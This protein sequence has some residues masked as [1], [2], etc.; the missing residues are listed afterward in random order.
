MSEHSAGVVPPRLL[1]AL[2]EQ[3]ADCP[4]LELLLEP[5]HAEAADRERIERHVEFCPI[6]AGIVDPASDEIDDLTWRGVERTL[7][8]RGRPWELRA[9]VS[10]ARERPRI[11][12]AIAAAALV[13][14]GGLAV[15][16]LLSGSPPPPASSGVLRG[17]PIQPLEPA[18]AVDSV[19]VFRWRIAAP[20]EAELHVEVERGE[21]PLWTPLWSGVAGGGSL[22]AP[23]SLREQL[24][25]GEY[26]WRVSGVDSQGAV[27]ARSVWVDFQIE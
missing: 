14:L 22:E 16:R 17:A 21:A 1:A 15:W 9:G 2:R 12:L 24:A 11:F 19:E 10:D 23:A 20:V 6:C 7:D 5:E 27:V 13:L 8:A 26:R 3:R 25:P 4:P 18:G